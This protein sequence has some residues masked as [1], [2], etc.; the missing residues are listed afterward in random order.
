MKMKLS[1][2][3]KSINE[4]ELFMKYKSSYISAF[5][6]F[7]VHV[8]LLGCSFYAL[9]YFRNSW[10]SVITMPLLG[11]LNIKTFMIFHDCGHNSYTPNKTLNYM[12]GLLL[13]G[14]VSHPFFWNYNHNT[15]HNVNGNIENEYNY[16]FNETVFHTLKQYKSFSNITRCVYKLVRTPI[17]FF[18]IPIYIKILIA[19]QFRIVKFILYQT[20]DCNTPK[21]YL[22]FEQFVSTGGLILTLY[23]CNLYDILWTFIFSCF[24]GFT[25]TVMTVHN[26][27]TYNPSYVVGNNDWNYKD[28]G[29]RGSSFILIPR[30]FR[31]FFHG[32]EYHHIHHMNA[33]IPGYNLQKY[34]EEVVSKSNMFDNIVKL[35]IADCYNNLWLCLYDEDNKKYIT[36]VE[37]DEE[38]RKYK[39]V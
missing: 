27:H 28:S 3:N 17:F 4:T 30:A 33:K 21:I 11:M 25:I 32:I 24:F 34:H 18:T 37:A 7:S 12:I 19:N 22:F 1:P 10:L 8:F 38:I 9:W 31:Y 16:V 2:I 13:S 26:E 36:F 14:F 5:T 6:D 29:L 15:H 20:Y 39:V 35:S 23:I